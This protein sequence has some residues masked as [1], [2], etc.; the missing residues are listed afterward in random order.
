MWGFLKKD[1]VPKRFSAEFRSKHKS[2]ID[3]IAGG[4]SGALGQTAAYPLDIVRRRMQVGPALRDS[5]P[6]P[7]PTSSTRTSTNSLSSK[8]F[9]NT[10]SS[11]N[12]PGFIQT[13]QQ[14]YA[15]AG[16]KGF[17]VG[18]S[19]GY[20]KVIPMNAVSFASWEA[21]KVVF[22]LDAE[23]TGVKAKD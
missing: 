22:G 15:L 23:E 4:I 3:L 16:W 2:A 19:I 21:L 14:V 9:H 12:R 17:F 6:L 20:L 1:L 8:L 11:I 18:L 7:S 10:K 5:P 13:A